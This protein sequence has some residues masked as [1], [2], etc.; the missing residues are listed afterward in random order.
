MLYNNKG[1]HTAAFII[2]IFLRKKRRGSGVLRDT[3]KAHNVYYV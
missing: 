2:A 1:D 3:K